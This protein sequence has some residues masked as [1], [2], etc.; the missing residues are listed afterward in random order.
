M[1][2]EPKIGPLP[3]CSQNCNWSTAWCLTNPYCRTQ[4]L[5]PRT[6]STT[7]ACA[8]C[9]VA[10]TTSTMQDSLVGSWRWR[11]MKTAKKGDML[12]LCL[13]VEDEW[14][15]FTY[16]LDCLGIRSDLDLDLRNRRSATLDSFENSKQ[17]SWFQPSRAWSNRKPG[18]DPRK[19]P[20]WPGAL[21]VI[22]NILIINCS[23]SSFPTT[24][25]P[26]CAVLQV[27]L[28]ENESLPW[29]SSW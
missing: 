1:S 4:L 29:W 8:T 18:N 27:D 28:K 17:M 25:L 3:K 24:L 22:I 10:T 19:L 13:Q 15:F 6:S 5:P 26:Y 11:P 9:L 16:P 23:C 7:L 20:S 12:N 21:F 14:I 2:P